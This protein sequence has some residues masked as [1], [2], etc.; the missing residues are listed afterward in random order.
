MGTKCVQLVPDQFMFCY[1]TDFMLSFTGIVDLLY[2]SISAHCFIKFEL[3]RYSQQCGK[4]T[5]SILMEKL[6]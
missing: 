2:L 1:E 3:K 6:R 4:M 5:A